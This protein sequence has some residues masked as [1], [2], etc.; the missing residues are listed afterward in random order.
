[1]VEPQP[2]LSQT[3]HHHDGIVTKQVLSPFED[4]AID[5]IE[6]II[7]EFTWRCLRFELQTLLPNI[8]HGIV[9]GFQRDQRRSVC[10]SFVDQLAPDSNS[11]VKV[12]CRKRRMAVHGSECHL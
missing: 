10:G 4:G 9:P 8:L 11:K 6:M 5:D 7:L 1:M 3:R 12:G 2:I